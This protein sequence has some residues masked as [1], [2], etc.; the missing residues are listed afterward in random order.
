MADSG[1]KARKLNPQR[2]QDGGIAQTNIGLRQGI[3]A[4]LWLVA[5]LASWLVVDANDLQALVCDAVDKLLPANLDG[6]HG[7][8]CREQGAG[9]SKGAQE[10]ERVSAGTHGLAKQQDS[11]IQKA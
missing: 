8:G 10:L 5:S 9:E 3:L 4:L 11:S 6:I 2:L 7:M 1:R